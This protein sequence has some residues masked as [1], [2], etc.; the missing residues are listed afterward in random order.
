MQRSR[1]ALLQRRSSVSFEINNGTTTN[2]M[3]NV[4][5]SLIVIWWLFFPVLIGH[6]DNHTDGSGVVPVGE[7]TWDDTEQVVNEG[8][9]SGTGIQYVFTDSKDS[10]LDICNAISEAKCT[11]N[12]ILP[13]LKENVTASELV[14]QMKKLETSF[15]GP[16]VE[17]D[18]TSVLSNDRLSH[19]APIGL[20][21]FKSK[22]LSGA[23]AKPASEPSNG[24]VHRVE[25]GGTE[26]NYA[27]ASKGAKVIDFNKEAKGASYILGKDKDKYLRN[28]CSAEVKF[29][30]IELSEETLVD[31]IE[32][33]NFEHYSSNLRDFQVLGSL[34]YPTDKW[35][36]LGNITAKNVKHAQ[37]FILEEPK[38]VRYLK[39]YLLNHYGSGFYCT[40]SA[41]GVYGMDAVEQMVED[42]ISVHE[43]VNLGQAPIRITPQPV[44]P[45][46]E[47]DW[48]FDN[49][50]AQESTNSQHEVP[51]NNGRNSVPDDQ[52]QQAGRMTGD[53]A[54]KILLQKVRS[55]DLGLSVL[56]RYLEELNSRYGKIFKELDDEIV[57]KD[58]LLYKYRVDIKKLLDSKEIVAKKVADLIGWKSLVSSQVN[59][60]VDDSVILR[61]EIARVLKNQIYMENKGVVI[62]LVSI[63]FSGIALLK[64]VIDLVVNLFRI[65]NK[66]EKFIQISSSW[67]VLLLSSSIVVIML[68]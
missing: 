66:S 24:V 32:V 68:L 11:S 16:K 14:E 27:S 35:L 34:V 57:A 43:E 8:F 4:I 29:V 48:D 30:V 61:A 36:H 59:N 25:A 64:L 47:D 21:E 18:S 12:E 31:T 3:Y 65:Q 51:K 37:R 19:V 2:H 7:S 10:D 41:V 39:F 26:Y 40:L 9:D 53:T 56:E 33:A 54:L 1:K 23:K 28:P 44:E 42:L 60:L 67:L 46:E 15:I 38:W 22:Q 20:D 49:E 50:S 52:P 5:L 13:T 63:I 17:K 6:S 55:M 45:A 62:L 58:V